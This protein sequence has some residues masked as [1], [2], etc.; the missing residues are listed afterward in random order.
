MPTNNMGHNHSN[1]NADVHSTTSES[2]IVFFIYYEQFKYSPFLSKTDSE[3][4]EQPT[5]TSS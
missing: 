1:H 2:K 3:S 5:D 4:I